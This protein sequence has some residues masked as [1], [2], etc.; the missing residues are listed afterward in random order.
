M[1]LDSTLVAMTS[2]QIRK[3]R[4]TYDHCMQNVLQ[5]AAMT[6]G[7]EIVTVEK[8]YRP[9]VFITRLAFPLLGGGTDEWQAGSPCDLDH[10]GFKGLHMLQK[11]LHGLSCI[12][13]GLREGKSKEGE[14]GDIWGQGEIRWADQTDK[15]LWLYISA[16]FVRFHWCNF[17]MLPI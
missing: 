17:K 16:F 14:A 1:L 12:N 8:W 6:H 5:W 7:H 9:P 4:F 10:L 13:D 11:G 2:R 15:L 3:I